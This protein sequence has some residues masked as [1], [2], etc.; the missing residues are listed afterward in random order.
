MERSINI[1]S[2]IKKVL[3]NYD[4]EKILKRAELFSSSDFAETFICLDKKQSDK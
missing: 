2:I 1:H 3:S 4:I